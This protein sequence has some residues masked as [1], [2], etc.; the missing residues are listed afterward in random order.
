MAPKTSGDKWTDRM[1]SAELFMGALDVASRVGKAG[2]S[3]VGKILMGEDFPAAQ[4][5]VRERFERLKTTKPAGT[6]STSTEIYLIGFGL[7]R[8]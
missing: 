4:R 1:R 2:S 7:R 8:A 3:F 5:S 6:R